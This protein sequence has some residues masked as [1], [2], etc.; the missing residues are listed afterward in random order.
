[1][2]EICMYSHIYGLYTQ[3]LIVLPV[4]KQQLLHMPPV[5]MHASSSYIGP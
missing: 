1:M 3:V 5:G 2:R 4:G